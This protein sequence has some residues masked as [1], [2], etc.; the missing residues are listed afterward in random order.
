MNTSEENSANMPL[1][2]EDARSYKS[3]MKSKRFSIKNAAYFPAYDL[4]FS[5]FVGKEI[6]FVEIGVLGGGSMQMWRDF[7]G[8]KARIIGIDTLLDTKELEKEGFEIFIGDQ[9]SPEFWADFFKKVGKVDVILDDGGHTYQQQIITAENVLPNIKDGGLLVTEDVNTSYQRYYAGPSRNSFISYAFNKVHGINYRYG[10]F[11]S[12][13]YR[14]GMLLRRRVRP[15]NLVY[16][17]TFLQSIVAYHVDR[18]LTAIPAINIPNK[19]D[20]AL[21]KKMSDDDRTHDD[22]LANKF[23][24]YFFRISMLLKNQ[25]LGKYFRH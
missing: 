7:L 23:G 25:F 21:L 24:L 17:M 15:D 8:A 16:S 11:T 18:R 6:T 13:K 9:A 3:F 20:K 10:I 2:Y 22:F 19:D 4:L 14:E 5:R 1:K 12:P